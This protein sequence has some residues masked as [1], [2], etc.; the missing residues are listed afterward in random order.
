MG[1]QQGSAC[2][3]LPDAAPWRMQDGTRDMHCHILLTAT[4]CK[5]RTVPNYVASKNRGGWL[6]PPVVLRARPDG[7]A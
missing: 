2:P 1:N 4:C 5:P 7:D 6:L 3:R